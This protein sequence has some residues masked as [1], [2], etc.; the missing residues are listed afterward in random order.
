MMKSGT[1]AVLSAA[2]FAGLALLGAAIAQESDYPNDPASLAIG[3]TIAE[4][5]CASCH[6]IGPE[7]ESPNAEAPAFRD[8]SQRYPISDLE[9]SLAEGIVT[10][11]NDMPEFVLQPDNINQFLGYLSS[12]QVQKDKN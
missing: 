5:N 10:G 8:L 2:F 3:R 9:E 11:H 4:E 6:A 12:I 7:G 1:Y